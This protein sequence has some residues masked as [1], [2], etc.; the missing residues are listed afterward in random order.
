LISIT[1][2]DANSEWSEFQPTSH[3][4]LNPE[5]IF[6]DQIP[7]L[8]KQ[9]PESSIGR[10]LSPFIPQGCLYDD[11]CEKVLDYPD[12]NKIKNKLRRTTSLLE[13]Q[14][15]FKEVDTE[16]TLMLRSKF[17]NAEAS[18]TESRLPVINSNIATQNSTQNL[19]AN[20][21][22]SNFPAREDVDF[23]R[24]SPACDSQESFVYPRTARN[25]KRQWRFVI[26]VPGEDGEDNYVQ[27]VKVEKCIRQGESCNIASSGYE[28]TVCKQKYTYRRLLAL[29]E[30][31]TQYVDSFRFPS[32]CICYQQKSFSYDFELLRTVSSNDTK[33]HDTVPHDTMPLKVKEK[34]KVQKQSTQKIENVIY[35]LRSGDKLTT[36][37]PVHIYR[38]KIH[39]HP[40]KHT[41]TWKWRRPKNNFPRKSMFLN[42][43]K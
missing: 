26:N 36:K 29:S 15:M 34:F 24:L 27:A 41:D 6:P 31:G 42:F 20:K 38:S 10:I 1:Y 40:T 18:D 22:E 8:R 16:E 11:Y 30:D 39:V 37:K 14:L 13:K 9:I 3:E 32:C 23:V 35:Q 33:P 19:T 25:R 43:G 7:R 12:T 21:L 28:A 2:S 5:F 4:W 17:K